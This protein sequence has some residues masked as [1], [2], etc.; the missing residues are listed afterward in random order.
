MAP[1][2]L[3]SRCTRCSAMMLVESDSHGVFATCVACGNV[4]EAKR[5]SAAELL[6]EEQLAAGKQ[7]RRQPSHG[8]LRL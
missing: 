7:R 4:H 1:D 8:A 5:I 3:P 2:P 6:A